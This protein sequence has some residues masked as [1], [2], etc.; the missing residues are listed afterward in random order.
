MQNIPRPPEPEDPHR[1]FAQNR[2]PNQTPVQA[3]SENDRNRKT[4]DEEPLHSFEGLPV[5]LPSEAQSEKKP[6]RGNEGSDHEAD[7][8]P[9]NDGLSQLGLYAHA[10]KRRFQCEGDHSRRKN[11]VYEGTMVAK[12]HQ[13][14]QNPATKSR[15]K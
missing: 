10:G 4:R 15:N 14:G 5:I 1:R 3:H 8:L 2:S 11:P 9:S 13:R 7:S 6:D 12:Q